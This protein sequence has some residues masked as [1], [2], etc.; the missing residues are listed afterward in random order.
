M[1]VAETCPAGENQRLE[2]AREA[3]QRFRLQCFWSWPDDPVINEKTI[4]L[5]VRGLRL[6][7]GHIGYQ[8]AASLCGDR[9]G[10]DW[11]GE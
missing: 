8:V 5:I 2:L 6:H 11:A 4:P 7:G 3:F 9:G 10:G 1:L